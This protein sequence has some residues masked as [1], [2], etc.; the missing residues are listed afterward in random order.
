MTHLL[1][2]RPSKYGAKRAEQD[3][4]TFD[5]LAEWRRYQELKLLLAAGEIAD[6]RVHPRYTLLEAF[7]DAQGRKHR[8]LVYVADFAYFEVFSGLEVV[9]DV[10]GMETR[11]FKIK[12]KLLCKQL[13][14]GTEFR[15]VKV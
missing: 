14:A 6:L 1:A 13:P 2:T 7:T 10:K 3:G 8:P 9:E 15:V 5:S 4:I 12:E 11:E